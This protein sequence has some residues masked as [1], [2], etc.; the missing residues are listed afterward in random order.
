MRQRIPAVRLKAHVVAIQSSPGGAA[1]SMPMR[2][3]HCGRPG[4]DQPSGHC[5]GKLQ[6][7]QGLQRAGSFFWEAWSRNPRGP[8][9]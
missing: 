5:S 3:R 1:T 6:A 9:L 7:A 8:A 4:F 2:L